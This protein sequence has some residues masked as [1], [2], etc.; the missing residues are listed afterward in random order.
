MTLCDWHDVLTAD[1][2]EIDRLK[3]ALSASK[4]ILNHVNLAVQ[5]CENRHKL[6]DL[7]RR[8]DTRYVESSTDPVIVQYRVS[9]A[10]II[11]RIV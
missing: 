10:H 9:S 2:D 6:A 1:P 5:E 7:Q 11:S 8:I 4:I 3:N